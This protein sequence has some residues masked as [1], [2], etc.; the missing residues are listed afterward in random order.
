[1]KYV[2]LEDADFELTLLH[3]S[4]LPEA[5]SRL[6]VIPVEDLIPVNLTVHL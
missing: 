5:V 6:R 1:L 3:D 2:S 4:Y